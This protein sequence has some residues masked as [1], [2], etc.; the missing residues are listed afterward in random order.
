MRLIGDT[1][2]IDLACLPIGDRYTM[3]PAHAAMAAEMLK[4]KAVLPIHYNTWPP[5]NQD[6][7]AFARKLQLKGITGLPLKAGESHEL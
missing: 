4:A 1:W 7:R 2:P 6:A 3:G 5:I